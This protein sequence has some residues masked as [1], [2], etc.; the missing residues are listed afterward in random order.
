MRDARDMQEPRVLFAALDRAHVGAIDVTS[1][2]QLF[3][4]YASLLPEPANGRAE[5]DQNFMVSVGR[6]DWHIA[7]VHDMMVITPRV[8]IPIGMTTPSPEMYAY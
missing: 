5:G 8:I 7:Y 1:Q 2:G 6:G 3:L 4:R